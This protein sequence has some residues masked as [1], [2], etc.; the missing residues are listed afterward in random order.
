MSSKYALE[1]NGEEHMD[2]QYASWSRDLSVEVY[3]N[4]Y[5]YTEFIQ[6]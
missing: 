1:E 6:L 3:T 5:V 4:N 2:E